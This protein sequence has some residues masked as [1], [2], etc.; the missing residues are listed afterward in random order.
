MKNE[1]LKLL[2]EKLVDFY[3][4]A[5]KSDVFCVLSTQT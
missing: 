3:I 1:Y 5:T 2:E 4:K